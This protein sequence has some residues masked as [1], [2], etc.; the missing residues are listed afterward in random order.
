MRFANGRIP[1]MLCPAAT[2]RRR[3][4]PS[5]PGLAS[6]RSYDA[7]MAR[8]EAIIPHRAPFLL[9]TDIDD[10]VAGVSARGRW[11]LSGEEAFWAGHFPGRPTLPGVLMVESIAQLGA[12]A[13]LSDPARAGKLP[14]FGGIDKARFRAQV[15]P[16]DTLEL[17][18]TLGSMGARGGKGS[19]AAKVGGK[20]ACSAELLFVLVDA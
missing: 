10:V 13:L 7:A 12:V 8:P 20:L 17:E 9:L 2:I 6:D 1:G 18:V 11:R 5:D 15:G 16:G 4:V 19:G 3:G 14:L